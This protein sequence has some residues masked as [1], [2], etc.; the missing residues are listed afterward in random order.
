M[1]HQDMIGLCVRTFQF[2]NDNAHFVIPE[3]TAC[4][5]IY[6]EFNRN[7]KCYNFKSFLEELLLQPFLPPPL[8]LPVK[9][10]AKNS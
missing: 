9:I 7:F 10:V 6:M 8:P 1:R 4:L 3:M 2:A 5:N